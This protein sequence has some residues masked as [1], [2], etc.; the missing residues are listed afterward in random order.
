[1]GQTVNN[2]IDP[3][4]ERLFSYFKWIIVYIRIFPAVTQVAFVCI[5]DN[6]PFIIE[7]AK[8]LGR[9]T[10][11]LVDL[12]QTIREFVERMVDTMVKW[13]FNER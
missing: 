7:Y 4:L 3:H 10:V 1:M 2:D 6:E 8:A 9:F 5:E 11:M 13:Q 12:G